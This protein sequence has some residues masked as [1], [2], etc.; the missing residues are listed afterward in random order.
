MPLPVKPIPVKD[1]DGLAF[2]L[3][4]WVRNVTNLLYATSGIIPVASGGTGIG[5]YTAGDLLYASAATTLAKLAIGSAGKFLQSVG[6]L[7][8]WSTPTWPTASPGAGTFPRGDGTNFVTSTLT[9]PNTLTVNQILYGT[10]TNA[11]GGSASLTF[12]AAGSA[13]GRLVVGATITPMSFF[14]GTGVVGTYAVSVNGVA[15]VDYRNTNSGNAA[16]FRFTV[17]SNDAV[18]Y[19]AVAVP[20]SGN[21][22]TLFGQTRSTIG[23]IFLNAISAS[24]RSL[25][26][27]TVTSNMMILGTANA[28]RWR[29]AATTGNLSNTGANGTAG[30]HLKAGT[31]AASTAPLKFTSGTSLTAAEAGAVEFTTDDLFFTITTGAARKAFVLDDGTRL[32]S[33]R[34]P[35]A[36]TNGRLTDDA[37]FA[38][39]TDTLTVTK[40]A[41]TTFTGT[42]ATQNI[43]PITDDTY[44]LGKNDDDTPKA[45]KG[46]ILKDQ[47]TGTYY[48]LQINSGAVALIDLTD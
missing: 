20:G 37:D 46:L 33:G 28:E 17:S 12:D 9:L 44:Y 2:G 23:T 43:E 32:T 18:D 13:S 30:I 45:W 4:E 8:V 16:D 24:S 35:F 15:G 41:A 36:T 29:L 19:L 21:T 39:A 27:G 5:S 40:I 48:R 10:G 34:V 38:F 42:I 26:I 7:P 11:A 22:A 6:G 31:T 1:L 47:T 14:S 25:A 3:K